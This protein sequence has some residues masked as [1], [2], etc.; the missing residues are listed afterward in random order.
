[1]AYLNQSFA[2]VLCN[3]GA[4]RRWSR[5]GWNGPGQYIELQNPYVH[6][7]M[8][9]PYLYIVTVEGHKVP[10]APTQEDLLTY[11]WYMLGESG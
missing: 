2:V 1:M 3:L 10:W 4:D 9:K 8:T 6:G 11:D 5:R 7:S